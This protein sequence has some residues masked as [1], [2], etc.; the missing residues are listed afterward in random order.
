M[1]SQAF[2]NYVDQDVVGEKREIDLKETKMDGPTF[3]A[4]REYFDEWGEK[5][6]TL[7]RNSQRDVNR[8]GV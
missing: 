5:D 1:S 8:E 7:L 4:L 6:P 3:R 2:K